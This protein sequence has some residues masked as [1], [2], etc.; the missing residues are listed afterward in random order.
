MM[1]FDEALAGMWQLWLHVGAFEFTEIIYGKEWNEDIRY[2]L[3][4][5]KK[6]KSQPLEYWY[7]L[8]SQHRKNF[9][10]A[11]LKYL[12]IYKKRIERGKELNSIGLDVG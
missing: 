7:E 2:H 1:T 11:A 3:R 10:R 4:E 9:E 5:W 6:F 12:N 8:D